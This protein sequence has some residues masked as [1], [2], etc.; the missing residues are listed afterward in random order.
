MYESPSY[1]VKLG[2]RVA[3]SGGTSK[4]LEQLEA[5]CQTFAPAYQYI[6]DESKKLGYSPTGRFP[7]TILSIRRKIV[8]ERTRLTRM[9]DIAG[10]R[11]V[12]NTIADQDA[13]IERLRAIAESQVTDRRISPKHGYRAVHIVFS[14]NGVA[15]ETQVRTALQQQWA[16]LSEKFADEFPEIKYGGGPEVPQALL[17]VSSRVISL[18]EFDERRN[19]SNPELNSMYETL[20]GLLLEI[21]NL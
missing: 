11:I 4:D 19:V 18:I 17:N 3:K 12:V 15:V 21:G 2:E 1:I 8:R 7:K 16:E 5:F 13:A 6:F 9:Q 10:I 20:Q 14:V